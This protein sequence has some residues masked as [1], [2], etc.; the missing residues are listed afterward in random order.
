[1]SLFK[2]TKV[3]D[4]ALEPRTMFDA[5]F[6]VDIAD[7]VV[8]EEALDFTGDLDQISPSYD[9]PNSGGNELFV[10]DSRVE[11]ADAIISSIAPD[12]LILRLDTSEGGFAQI[13]AFTQDNPELSAIHI[14]GHGGPGFLLLGDGLVTAQTMLDSQADS[15]KNLGDALGDDADILIYGCNFAEGVV[16]ESATTIMAALTGA[17]IAASNDATGDADAGGDW[18]L[19]FQ[20]DA[21][22][23]EAVAIAGFTTLLAVEATDGIFTVQD[24]DTPGAGTITLSDD[25]AG[26]TVTNANT[27]RGVQSMVPQV[28]T[29]EETADVGESTIVIDVSTFVGTTGTVASDFALVISDQA[30]LSLSTSTVLRASGFDAVNGLV[31]FHKVNLA[32]GNYIGVATQTET[33]NISIGSVIVVDE[34]GLADL[35]LVVQPALTDGG[36]LPD[37]FATAV[38]FRASDAGNTPTEFLIPAGTTNI[39]ITGNSSFDSFTG[40]NATLDDDFQNMS[41]SIDLS[42][43]LSGGYL[44]YVVDQGPSRNDQFS[45]SDVPLGTGVLDGGSTEGNLGSNINPV[46]SIVEGKLQI[47]ENTG[48]ETAYLVEFSTTLNS[49]SNFI[50]SSAALADIGDQTDIVIE[51]PAGVDYIKIN[52]NDAAAGSNSRV[53]YKGYSSHFLDL[54]TGSG[55]GSIMAQQGSGSTRTVTYGYDSYDFASGANTSIQTSGADVVGD[56]TSTA[57]VNNDLTYYIDGNG[58]LVI[59]RAAGHADGFN[60]MFTVEFYDRLDIGSSAD[61]MGSSSDSALFDA[62][63]GTADAVLTFEAPEGATLGL[64]NLSMGGT[65]TNNLNENMGSGF[66]IIN[67]E[68]GVTSG[69]MFNLRA[70]SKVD[71]LSW[72]NV[73]SGT[74][75]FDVANGSATG[76]TATSNHGSLGVFN[77]KFIPNGVFEITANADGTNTVEF[78]TNSSD[79]TQSFRDYNAFA[80]VQWLGTEPIKLT[81]LPVDG[82]FNIGELNTV[83]GDWEIDIAEAATNGLVYTPPEH[84]SGTLPLTLNVSVGPESD[85]TLIIQ[86]PVLDTITFDTTAVSGDED[87]Q[88]SLTDAVNPTFEDDDGSETITSTLLSGIEVGHTITDGTNTFTATAG[89]QSV[90][91]SSWD[92]TALTYFA[93]DNVNGVF[94]LTVVVNY[95]DT[96]AGQT[97]SG[98][99]S[100][101]LTV[102]VLPVNDAPDAVDDQYILVSSA[103]LVTTVPGVLDNDSDVEND[104]LTVNT[105]PVSGP[106]HGTLILN[107]DGSFTYVNSGD[108]ATADQFTYSVSDGRGGVSEAT[109]FIT[110]SPAPISPPDAVDDAVTTNE[111]TPITIDVLDNDLPATGPIPIVQA[112]TQPANGTAS[113]NADGTIEYTPDDDFF[114]GV[115]DSFTYTLIDALGQTDTATVVVTVNNVQDAPTALPDSAATPEDVSV[116]INVLANDNDVDGDTLTI[117]SATSSQGSVTIE[118]NG[119]LTFVPNSNYSGPATINY[120]IND[121]NGNSVSSTVAVTVTAQ[122]DAPDSA[123]ETVTLDEDS[124]YTFVPS[125]FAFTDGDSGDTLQFIDFEAP[126]L[127]TLALNGTPITAFPVRVTLTQL[128]NG[129]LTY[130]PATNGSGPTYATMDFLVSDGQLRD[131]SANTITFDVTPIDDEIVLSGTSLPNQTMVD[132][133]TGVSITTAE[134]FT[135]V[136]STV[137]NY[138]FAGA[139]VGLQVDAS[140]GVITSIAA[141][142]DHLASDASPYTVAVTATSADGTS[143]TTSFL[144]A[145]SNPAPVST[146]GG[147]FEYDDGDVI[148]P[149][150]VTT[151]FSDPDMDDLT[152]T[153]ESGDIP[154]DLSFDVNT[155]ILSGTISNTAS[156][157]V[158]YTAT[159]RATDEQGRSTT[160]SVS[161]TVNNPE[162]ALTTQIPNQNNFDGDVVLPVAGIDLDDFITDDDPL[163]FVVSGLPEG[164]SY[165]AA[166]NVIS[167]TLDNSASQSG[168]DGSYAISVIAT[169]SQG[170]DTEASFTW[171]IVNPIPVVDTPIPDEAVQDGSTLEIPLS[172]VFSDPDLDSLT[173]TASVDDPALGSITVSPAGI[174]TV[175]VASSASQ[176]NGGIYLL[177]I[178]A[179]DG[180]GGTTAELVQITVTNPPPVIETLIADQNNEDADT[181][182]LDLSSNFADVDN[183]AVTYSATGL[184]AIGLTIDDNGLITGTIPSSASQTGPYPITIIATD[185]DGGVGEYSFTW[186]VTNPVP[187]AGTIP[188]QTAV[189]GQT[190]SFDAAA[191]GG[192]ADEDV[193][194]YS[195]TG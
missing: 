106:S 13:E 167:G 62:S 159:F 170:R 148:T 12:A 161:F 151:L 32:D 21:V 108:G 49:S 102:T 2:K 192:F 164:L 182:N 155:G 72:A 83:T 65:S 188:P 50:G 36:S 93:G 61:T 141:G 126:S 33:D 4:L 71:L 174:V 157:L 191:A 78:I 104:I 29:Y 156:A 28:W 87:T 179:D 16:G 100:D 92:D 131:T 194:A 118:A 15:L 90:D 55:S 146:P 107:N 193:L 35:N 60:S 110:I 47:V 91:V 82:S 80:N 176:T 7:Q 75:M 119:T 95:Q 22:E 113:I 31:Y 85:E 165:N 43:G 145:V 70:S 101:T 169:D 76:G 143:V 180:E 125:D 177:T 17:E 189:D 89:S 153:L 166:T 42:T 120:T 24:S 1:M 184:A 185:A 68:T 99:Q 132:G 154:P 88:I 9:D 137:A 79:G 67:L 5:A 14:F 41:V 158:T 53:E 163:T 135:D 58:D 84:F 52:Q 150:D 18:A 30:D 147:D 123:D 81:G 63:P 105:T 94:D 168:V 128:T 129:G 172:G 140:T 136:D 73:P 48:L 54:S 46:F 117:V 190:V 138:A 96:G 26:L 74:N 122:P 183:D 51:I 40:S 124:I 178:T 116:N 121:G 175:N 20:T 45:W 8:S 142:V 109:V 114:S 38:G 10:I 39:T 23:A 133:E 69:S 57:A 171:N 111:E 86:R 64:L 187:T 160:S 162:P 6:A 186:N 152:F 144:I 27:P 56:T 115:T 181:V 173:F 112:I 3:L 66:V 134:A 195:V 98:S 25:G 97:V 37:T 103:T 127:G 44:A 130:Q 59:S 34:D 11:N 77:D 19:E 139:P 149:I